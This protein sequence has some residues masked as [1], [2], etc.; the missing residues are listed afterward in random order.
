IPLTCHDGIQN[1]GETSIDHGGPCLM[2]DEN[3]LEPSAVLWTRALKVRGGL[4]DAITYIDNPNQSA[5]VLSAPYQLDMY[6]SQNVLVASVTGTTFVMPGGVTPVFIGGVDTGN[7]EAVHAQFRF[8]DP[9]QW[10]RVIGIAQGIVISNQQVSQDASSSKVTA[11]VTNTS[12]APIAN[13]TFVATVFD[14]GGN[15]IAT[16]QTALPRLNAQDKQQ[17]FFTW[18]DNFSAPVGRV[19]IIAVVAPEPDPSAHR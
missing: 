8:T 17:I 10:E 11:F 18:P 5:G 6:D 16:S 1:Q 12:V 3:A 2:L 9:L 7:R 15:A 19:D 4:F 13:L 14:P